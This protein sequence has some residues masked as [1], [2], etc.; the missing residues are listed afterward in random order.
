MKLKKYSRLFAILA[1]ILIFAMVIGS[2]AGSFFS[3]M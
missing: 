3:I 2:I 1:L